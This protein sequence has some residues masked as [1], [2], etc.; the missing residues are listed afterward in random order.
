MLAQVPNFHRLLEKNEID[1]EQFTAGKYKRTVTMFGENTESDREKFQ[2]DLEQTH[3]LFKDFVAEHRSEL[4]IEQVAT[5]EHW[6]GAQ[7]VDL[8]LV[9]ELRTSDDYLLAAREQAELYEVIYR[10]KKPLVN[11]LLA[12]TQE[13]LREHNVLN[14]DQL[15]RSR[16]L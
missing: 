8:K 10:A 5:G 9:D 14:Q 12:S 13:A 2:E 7:A 3:N 1:F 6:Y 11:R 4:D 15:S 16:F